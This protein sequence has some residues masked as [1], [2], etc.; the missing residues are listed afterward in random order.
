MIRKIDT[1]RIPIKLW[2]KDLESGAL[3]QAKDLAN[4]S[5]AFSHIAI[6]PDAHQGC[7]LWKRTCT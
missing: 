6:M 7:H 2:I 4:L 3:Q 1:E 5:I